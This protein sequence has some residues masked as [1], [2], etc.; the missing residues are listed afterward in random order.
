MRA[1]YL[2][3]FMLSSITIVVI[4]LLSYVS[5]ARADGTV[6]Y[7]YYGSDSSRCGPISPCRTYRYAS[8]R[9]CQL[10]ETRQ[11]IYYIYSISSGYAGFCDKTGGSGTEP[12]PR[13]SG[14]PRP[15][16]SNFLWP[17]LGMAIVGFALGMVQGWTLRRGSVR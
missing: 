12:R 17:I 10:S 13:E 6:Y 2:W 15:P 9:A 7:G 8:N 1:K 11:T 3:A 4:Y 16:L 5:I 14:I